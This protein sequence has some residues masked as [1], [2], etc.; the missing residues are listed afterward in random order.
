M[1]DKS[2]PM[3]QFRSAKPPKIVTQEQDKK[4]HSESDLQSKICIWLKRTYPELLFISDF[5]AGIHLSQFLASLRSIQSCNYKMVDL[6]ILR[7]MT[8]KL[9]SGLPCYHGLCLE[10]KTGHDKVFM[11][12]RIT[13]LKNEHT[14]SQYRTIKMLRAQGYAAC[15]GCGEIEIKKLVVDYMNCIFVH[16]VVIER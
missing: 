2:D 6:I 13:L 11:Q 7:P 1:L 3:N 16:P 9:L 5:A 12:D 10:L 8:M 15:F 4:S 14:L